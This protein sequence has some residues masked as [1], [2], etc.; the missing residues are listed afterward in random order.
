MSLNAQTA[1]TTFGKNRV[2]HKQFDWK[3]ISTKHFN[4]YYYIGGNDLAHNTARHLETSFEKI[5][6]AIGYLPFERINILVYNSDSDLQQSN[7][8]LTNSFSA[9]GETEFIKSQIEI[10]YKGSQ[11]EYFKDL[12][13]NLAKLFID[14]IIYGGNFRDKLQSTYLIDFP[15]WFLSGAAEYMGHGTNEEMYNAVQNF[16][17]RKEKNPDRL[18][19]R[20]ATLI[21]Q[22]I[23]HYINET[24]G[25]YAIANILALTKASRNE[26]TGI[27]NSLGVPYQHFIKD[28]LMFYS[29]ILTV[30]PDQEK[31]KIKATSRSG[32]VT[33]V[34][35]NRDQTKM[36]YAINKQG[37]YYVVVEDIESKRKKIIYYG[38]VKNIRWETDKSIP[39]IAWRSNEEL[40]LI[41]YK[42]GKPYLL[43]KNISKRFT[44]EKKLFVTFDAI[45][46]FHFS[47]N[48]TDMVLSGIKNGQS[49][50]FTYNVKT[51]QAKQ[52]TK[53]L[54]D[55]FA[56]N[57]SPSGEKIIFSSNRL[58]DT[59]RSDYGK[60]STITTNYNLFEFSG[61][62][63][64]KRVTSNSYT[65]SQPQYKTEN[66]IY[67]L[68][69]NGVTSK[70]YELDL[71]HS[72]AQNIFLS[73]RNIFTYSIFGNNILYQVNKKSKDYI[74]LSRQDSLYHRNNYLIFHHQEII[75]ENLPEEV[76]INNLLT[77]DPF[78]TSYDSDPKSI[79]KTNPK[80]TQK[81][82]LADLTNIS[83]P[84]ESQPLYSID[85]VI[86][87]IEVDPIRNI[88][89]VFGAGTSDMFGNHRISAKLFTPPNLKSSKI[90]FQYELLK[91]NL[92]FKIHLLKDNYLRLDDIE[93]HKQ[94]KTEVGITVSKPFSP[95]A[96]VEFTTGIS[97]TS[98][99]DYL[100]LGTLTDHNTYSK[101]NFQ[102]V[103]DNTIERALNQIQGFRM[104]AGV[105][106]LGKL[107]GNYGGYNNIY[108]DL[109]NYQPLVRNIVFASRFSYGRYGGKLPRVYMLG[110]VDNWLLQKYNDSPEFDPLYIHGFTENPYL[111]YSDFVTNLRGFNYNQMNG[112]SHFLINT[113]LRIPVVSLL[114]SGPVTSSF[115]RNLQLNLFYE[116]GSAWNGA[117]PF[118]EDNSINT[119]T[120]GGN[121]QA[122][123]AN[124]INYQSPILS[125]YG[126]GVRSMIFGYYMKIDL[127]WGVKNYISQKPK[128]Q[129]SLGYDF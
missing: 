47:P 93:V 121:G 79:E 29:E 87:T 32:A 1:Q 23:Y 21:G 20:N 22:S 60:Y 49:D 35:V 58:N 91:Y 69:S 14:I 25:E 8:S 112:N 18:T 102:F 26:E 103:Y 30:N 2:Q 86:S 90:N 66:S 85:Y 80:K 117:H 16:I 51:N 76:L 115:F 120:I 42:N 104:K 116:L 109:R 118:G 64:L 11:T 65:E 107:T 75:E 28:W 77:I 24:Y 67:F 54:Y 124:V 48:E 95:V 61:S 62:K 88:G 101:N 55:D 81:T 38:G 9:G 70:I 4:V 57:Y 105:D 123:T 98:F 106:F 72:I 3:Y 73:E 89:G 19:G 33:Q 71:T 127:G 44:K 126:F 10:S 99:I 37:V 59:L 122:F 74:Y 78:E 83:S 40:S 36:A 39:L 108:L 128:L 31:T 43:T 15:A 92:D 63:I 114:Y 97:R 125:T 100:S 56:P 17:D 94:Y 96:R 113:E 82:N 5:T 7:I 6:H 53:D 52:I 13:K 12:D 129:I 84:K 45:S 68:S 41:K 50:I 110:G 119:R 34:K 111:L 27:R 46:S